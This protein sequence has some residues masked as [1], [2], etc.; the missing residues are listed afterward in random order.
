M[1]E[2]MPYL[3]HISVVKKLEK[4]PQCTRI[5]KWILFDHIISQEFILM[6]GIFHEATCYGHLIHIVPMKKERSSNY[7]IKAHG[8]EEEKEEEEE[9]EKEVEKHKRKGRGENDF[10]SMNQ[11]LTRQ[12]EPKKKDLSKTFLIVYLQNSRM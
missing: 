4:G 3:I 10:E 9:E 7:F 6:K 12:A 1:F 5:K 11:V 2:V 8:V